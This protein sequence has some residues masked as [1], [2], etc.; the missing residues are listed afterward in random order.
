MVSLK[1]AFEPSCEIMVLFILHKLILK[2]CMR[3]HPVW[4]DVRFS[5]RTIRLLPYLM[6]ANCEGSGET[7]RMRMLA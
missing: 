1:T 7:A 2:L 4:L 3:N 5:G 6:C